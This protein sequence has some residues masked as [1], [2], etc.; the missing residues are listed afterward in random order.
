MTYISIK[1]LKKPK[2]VRETLSSEHQLVLTK[3]GTPFALM[4]EVT[5]DNVEES[6]REVRRAMFSAAV[7]KA[8]RKGRVRPVSDAD[9]QREVTAVRVERAGT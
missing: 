8:R 4:V 1:D 2:M 6:L 7:A 3:D 5:P 9:V